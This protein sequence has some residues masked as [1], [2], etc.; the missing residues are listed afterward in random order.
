[1]INVQIE[2]DQKLV[3]LKEKSIIKLVSV[4]MK[5]EDIKTA[6]ILL[7]FTTDN[8]LMELKKKYFNQE[9]YTD[10][11][12]FRLNDYNEDKVEGE[13]YISVPQVRN[14]AK[15]YNQAFNKELSRIIIH[16]SLHLLNYK[17]KTPQE[18]IKMTEKEDYFLN[19][20]N[21]ENIA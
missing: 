15:Q 4:V 1:M 11:I 8:V 6:E 21:W 19:K 3:K 10:V 5:S 20:I 12:A 17:D 9:H 7:I 18:K 13:I 16:G 14:N 2:T